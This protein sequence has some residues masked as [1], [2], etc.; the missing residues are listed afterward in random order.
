MEDHGRRHPSR[1]MTS[2]W[3]WRKDSEK[4]VE[5][6]I[7]I[8]TVPPKLFHGAQVSN[9]CHTTKLCLAVSV[10]WT[11][12]V[13]TLSTTAAAS[14]PR[15]QRCPGGPASWTDRATPIELF[16]CGAVSHRKKPNGDHQSQTEL[17]RPPP[18]QWE[19]CWTTGA[20]PSDSLQ[21]TWAKTCT[22]LL[23]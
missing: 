1:D 14:I 12:F 6:I 20:S 9:S 23:E 11:Q 17:N 8:K 18:R 5:K 21:S 13:N 16:S 19:S 3:R 15:R 4:Y 10:L 7:R 2:R 22:L